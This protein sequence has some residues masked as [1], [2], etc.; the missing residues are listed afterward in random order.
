MIGRML[1]HHRIL[2]QIG[3]GGMGVVYLAE[4]TR[5]GRRVALKVLPP[6]VAGD[7]ARQARFEREARLVAALN[8]PNIVTIH[9]VEQAEG[10]H[11]LT[12]ELVD[13]RRLT[14]L[15]PGD[16]LPLPRL[17]EWAAGIADAL[18]AAHRQ[19]VVHRDLKPDN[20]MVTAEGRLKVLDFGLAK[21]RETALEG[22]RS[23]A[24]TASV[25]GEGKIVGTVS[26]MSPE[27]AEAKPLD[28]R[29]DIFS[30]GIILYEMATGRRPFQGDTP[31]ST[32]SSILKD[33]PPPLQQVNARMPE[34]L[35]RIVRRCLAKEPDRRFQSTEDLRNELRELKE[36][37]ESGEL[38]RERT[39]SVPPPG[40]SREAEGAAARPRT[41]LWGGLAVA[42]V[43][44]VAVA[45]W[46]WPRREQTGSLP[47]AAA[48]SR[49]QMSRVTTD[50]SVSEAGISPD[51]R[52]V[53]YVR[54][55][56]PLTSLRL[57]QLATGEEVQVVAPS[58]AGLTAPSFS[59]DGDFLYYSY[60]EPGRFTGTVYRVSVLGGAPRRLLDGV[61]VV[62]PSPDGRR[63]ALFVWQTGGAILR[64]A[65]AEGESPRDLVARTGR[66][67]FDS[68]P[69]W[70][71]DGRT[72][73][74]VSHRYG[75]PQQVVLVDADS[76]AERI[77][78][79]KT[80]RAV[81]AV[82]W[83][84]GN[85][86]LLVTG[87]EK[88]L[89]QGAPDQ[90]W[91]I[92]AQGE[93]VPLTHDLN[94]YSGVT[95][96]KDGSTIAAVQVERRSG[97]DVADVHAGVPGQL[98]ELFPITAARYGTG[99]LAWLP[100]GKL[101]HASMSGEAME[102]FLTDLASRDTRQLTTGAP[103]HTPAASRDGRT[104]VVVR[105]EQ[106]SSRLF[107]IDPATGNEER[108]TDGPFDVFGTLNAD[109][110]W[111]VWSS[112]GD[113]ARLMK[114]AMTPGGS[115]VELLREA[116]FCTD[117]SVD[118]RMT[119]LM[120]LPTGE[121]RPIVVPLAGGEPKQAT[122]VPPSARI[123]KFG[124]DGRTIT[125]LVVAP[126]ACEIWSDVPGK[127][128]PR[129]LARI[130]GKEIGNY[131]FS[132]DG[133]HLAVVKYTDSGDVVLLKKGGG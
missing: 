74:I 88:P 70:S 121:T 92:S 18:V 52:Y 3:K 125:W 100:G 31:I 72:I 61:S 108:L 103:H 57:R 49:L 91:Q 47:S 98:T 80:L 71:S 122:Q 53:A 77:L 19:G 62:A 33:T 28:H 128:E 133:T 40:I 102:V 46:L 84:P 23:I 58:E 29:S 30:F 10:I 39:A 81:Q 118:E 22:G 119:C 7:P 78:P 38:A 99:G 123:E 79:Q 24:A 55:Q 26:Y 96:M 115:P 105:D 82:S 117:V 60:L 94:A 101:L 41:L 87:S 107:R 95:V 34:H 131:A 8:H 42:L 48:V 64:V 132:P 112:V 65:G 16:G 76:G 66:D 25:T 127:A 111:L 5:L 67:H 68:G 124:P 129:M 12:M 126:G 116:M 114:R 54:R 20:I 50:G 27:Q 130:E 51:G 4:D 97:I 63:L 75:Q 89:T 35:G 73:A 43:A 106:E 36:E 1:G 86:G 6:E 104:L 9:S 113:T 110:S 21:L 83:L 93:A 2:D 17:L 45:V 15:L 32:I 85:G 13:G 59:A 11:F 90:I 14:E 109:G 37:S 44:L 56:G 120:A 69:A